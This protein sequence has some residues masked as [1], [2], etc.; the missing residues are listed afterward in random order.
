MTCITVCSNFAS[1]FQAPTCLA[2]AGFARFGWFGRSGRSS[3]PLCDSHSC[4][5]HFGP[6]GSVNNLHFT[7]CPVV[8]G[9]LNICR[10]S[11]PLLNKLPGIHYSYGKPRKL[12]R[13]TKQIEDKLLS[14]WIQ[15]HLDSTNMIGFR[16]GHISHTPTFAR[17]FFCSDTQ[18]ACMIAQ[19]PRASTN[20]ESTRAKSVFNVEFL[21]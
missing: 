1:C 3:S 16:H 5:R 19:N 13:K 20:K 12:W 8:I 15:V 14:N 4:W 17:D 7:R 18:C 6:F 10:V 9:Y 11:S 21:P 2:R